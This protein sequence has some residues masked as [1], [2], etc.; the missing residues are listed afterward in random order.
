MPSRLPARAGRAGALALA[1]LGSLAV[2]GCTTTVPGQASPVPYAG[3]PVTLATPVLVRPVTG[4]TSHLSPGA[5]PAQPS[6]GAQESVNAPDRDD[7][8]CYPLAPAVLELTELDGLIIAVGPS[9]PGLQMFLVEE[10][11]ASFATYTQVNVG[12]QVGVVADGIVLLAP[13][14]QGAITGRVLISG[15]DQAELE[16]L[17]ETL[18][19]G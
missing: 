16:E 7:A 9:G 8:L 6:A 4:A 1:L 14:I 3:R 5:C 10:D 11:S 13:V 15:L 19:N 12:Q 2:S 18:V 17:R